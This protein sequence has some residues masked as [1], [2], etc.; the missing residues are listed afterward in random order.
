MKKY[1][2]LPQEELVSL[3][4]GVSEGLILNYILEATNWA[5]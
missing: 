5:E 2:Y 1:I 3:S 4:L